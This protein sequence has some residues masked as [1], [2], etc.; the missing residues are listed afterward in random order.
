MRRTTKRWLVAL[1]A[2]MVG[3][4]LPTGAVA[5]KRPSKPP[6]A[7]GS[8][9]DGLQAFDA[10]R[11]AKADGWKNG[12]PFD[13][14]WLADRPTTCRITR[15]ARPQARRGREPRRAVFL[16]RDAQQ[17]LLRPWLL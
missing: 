12:S 5:A 16:G 17:G 3:T 2:L 14:A 8:F 9:A 13:N 1:G 11:W 4:T 10:T 15:L 6:T 7:L